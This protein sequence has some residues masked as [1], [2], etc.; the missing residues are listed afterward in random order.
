MD[1]TRTRQHLE[2][3]ERLALRAERTLSR[4]DMR[5]R[6]LAAEIDAALATIRIDRRAGQGEQSTMFAILGDDPTP[7]TGVEIDLRPYQRTETS[8]QAA[9]GTI[10]VCESD[11]LRLLAEKPDTDDGLQ[12]RLE[13]KRGRR[14]SANSV[15]P[16]RWG[17][18]K[19]KQVEQIGTG[20]TRSGNSAILWGINDAGR[21]R[22][23]REGNR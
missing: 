7:P 8:I 6:Q 18:A 4:G 5:A 23:R 1:T 15:H 13:A 2:S 12:A 9:A 16:R 3:L 19:K 11:V 22:L 20:R 17:L 21:E 10:G 14:V